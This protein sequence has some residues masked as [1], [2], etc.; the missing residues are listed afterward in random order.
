M[1]TVVLYLD[2][3]NENM[4]KILTALCPKEVELRFYQPVKGQ[5]GELKDANV[6][7]ATGFV[8]S[9]DII[10]RAPNLKLIQR[11]GVGV[12]TTDLEYAREKG[13]PVSICKG[14]NSAPVAE[15]VILDILGLYRRIILLDGLTKKGEWH[16]WTYRH[17]SYELMGKT[18]GILGSGAI[19]K[20]VMKRLKPFG[21]RIIYYNTHRMTAEQEAEYNAE[22]KEFNQLIKESDII[23]V[24]LPWNDSTNGMIGMEQFNMMKK[25]AILINTSRGPIVDQHA[26]AEALRNKT[27]WGAASDVYDEDPAN[28]NDP[29]FSLKGVN[30]ITTPHI[31]AATYDNYRRVYEFCFDNCLRVNRGEEPE[32][33][34]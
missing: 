6:I 4:E 16:T 20:E 14:L 3:L 25:N 23:T 5:K 12:D 7:L 27:I 34:I 18:V 33:I 26:L 29:L 19:G 32:I 24:H 22:Y 9:G 11:T 13:I 8:V 31:G 30:L 15:L 10:D 1:S 17:D 21:T 2:K 28:P